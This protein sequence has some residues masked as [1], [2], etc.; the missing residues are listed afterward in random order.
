VLKRPRSYTGEDTVEISCHGSSLVLE[1]LVQAAISQGA[2]LAAPGGFTRRAFLNG[3]LDLLQA[4]AVID[5]IQ[6]GSKG[7]LESAYGHASGRLSRLVREVKERIIK[8]LSRV[9]IGLD[10][11]EED[12]GEIGREQVLGEVQQVIELATRLAETFEGSRR[13]QSGLLIAIIG[14]PNVGKSTLLNALLGEERAIVTPVPGT[15]RDLVEG[16]TVWNGELVRLVDTAGVRPVGDLVEQEGINRAR[17]IAESAN[18]VFAVLDVSAEW[19]EEDREVLDFLHGKR[20]ILVLNKMDLTP[21]LV[22]PDSWSDGISYVEISA[23]TGQGLGTLKERSM[24]VIPRPGLVDGIGITRQRHHD[25]LL[26]VIACANQARD[27]L[28]SHQL[29]ECIGA[30][31]QEGLGA[32][33]EMLGESVSEDVLDRIFS[34]FCIG[35]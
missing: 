5:L 25:C 24:E 20:G 28:L 29:D 19:Q 30:E 33:G 14:R 1:T 18:L 11:T 35:K 3:R 10:F 26:R 13:R 16:R 2:V 8:A 15:T 32:L 22:V 4:E 34:D 6:A 17:T 12:I 27:L 21:K 23:L 31:L 7:N 9:E